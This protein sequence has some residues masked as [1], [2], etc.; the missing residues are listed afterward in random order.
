[1]KIASRRYHSGMGYDLWANQ[2]AWFWG[3]VNLRVKGGIVGAARTKAEAIRE[4]RA[5]IEELSNV[6]CQIQ[7]PTAA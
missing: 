4:A 7:N 5:A 1:M 2:G 3:L 6:F